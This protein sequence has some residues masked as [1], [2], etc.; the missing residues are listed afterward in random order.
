MFFQILFSY[1][2][3]QFVSSRNSQRG[4]SKLSIEKCFW[5]E[6]SNTLFSTY[7]LQMK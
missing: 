6:T 5:K 2:L 4:D 7:I 1:T 3:K